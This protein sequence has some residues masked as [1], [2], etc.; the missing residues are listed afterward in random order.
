MRG[1]QARVVAVL[2]AGAVVQALLPALPPR[3]ALVADNVLLAVIA[4]VTL[5]GHIRQARAARGRTRLGWAL[6]AAAAGSWSASSWIDTV[7]VLLTATTALDELLAIV[8]A[9]LAVTALGLVGMSGSSGGEANLR[10]LID[11]ATVAGALF[12]LA[13]ELVL[14]PAYAAGDSNRTLVVLVLAPEITGAA[15]AV[16][17]LSRSLSRN[18]DQA[19][20]LL[21]L[22]LAAF[23][24]TVLLAVH[25]EAEDLPWYA[26]GVGAGYVVAGL[27]C[28][29]A[30]RAPLP[31]ETVDRDEQDVGGWAMLPYVPVAL[32]FAAAAW[33]YLHTGHLTP[34]LFWLLLA[35]AVLVM[36]RQFLSLRTTTRLTRRLQDQRERLAYQAS[37]DGLTGLANRTAFQAHASAV[38][39]AAGAD[40]LTGVLVLDLDG[41][42]QV[43]D[44]L[45]HAAGDEL[46]V[47]V[48]D[49]LRASVRT[50]DT[51]ARLG[52]DEFVILLPRLRRAE[53][54]E[55]V[56]AAILRRLAEPVTLDG[57][58]IGVRA[59]IGAAVASGSAID[60][61]EL[62]KQADAA[63]YQAKA[64][65]KGVLRRHTPAGTPDARV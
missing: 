47:G 36:T 21:A 11:V 56:G 57:R 33:R 9:L 15:Y 42:K 19:L 61:L 14:A 46:L 26:T 59:S 39:D 24:A 54:I 29:L 32:A 64:G 10:R 60:A 38:L 45:G 7:G 30:S 18:S 41:F 55:K 34:V 5:A 53:D 50:G 3:T 35:T 16:V 48:A 49:Q 12:F 25:N 28:A 52:G 37:H 1:I 31:T 13:W 43:N 4:M 65:G 27:L 62:V 44:T 63:L 8:A 2:A 51:V 22:S 23:A 20:S 58:P 17:L 40:E 6:A